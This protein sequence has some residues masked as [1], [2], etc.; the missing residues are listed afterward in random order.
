MLDFGDPHE[1]I[2]TPKSP[3][4][5]SEDINRD[6]KEGKAAGDSG[7]NTPDCLS[8]CLFPP[9]NEK[10]AHSKGENV[11]LLAQRSGNFRGVRKDNRKDMVPLQQIG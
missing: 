3:H 4:P 6:T 2:S 10:I 7:D 9:R 11:L 5:L 8:A 1:M